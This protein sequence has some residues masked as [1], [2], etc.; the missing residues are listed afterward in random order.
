MARYE[1]FDQDTYK[2][3]KALRQDVKDVFNKGL[4]PGDDLM[5]QLYFLDPK[6]RDYVEKMTRAYTQVVTPDDFKQIASIMSGYLRQQ[7]PI[8]TEFTKYYGR[9]GEAYMK[10]AKPKAAAFDYNALMQ[11]AIRG[12]QNKGSRPSKTVPKWLLSILSIKDESIK[13]QL[14]RKIPG[15]VPGSTLSK[16]VEGVPV[17]TRRRTGTKIGGV[18]LFSEDIVKGIEVGIP[19]KL[20]KSWTNLPAVNF[21]RKVLEQNYTQVFEEKLSYKDKD[22]KWITNILQV[23]QKT[24]PTWWEQFRNKDGK[25]NDI[26][27]ASRARTAYGVSSNHSN[28]A[29]LVKRHHLWGL[30]NGIPTSTIHDAFM[31]NAQHM[32]ASRSGLRQIYAGAV[33]T[34]T[35]KWTLDEMLA[36]GFP[37]E[38][39]DQYLEEAEMLGI[40]PVA[41]K[42]IVGGKVLRAED[43]LKRS[44][45]LKPIKNDFKDNY[46]FYGI[47]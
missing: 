39:Y 33:D 47:G 38:L 5:E 46:S 35:L 16:I 8:L 9:L 40:I 10:N 7:V 43:I 21:D 1:S 23:P 41:G 20:D 36:R 15:Y 31:G 18:S 45:V 4:N 22:G 30:K 24:D 3:L 19:N 25:I 13:Q 11:T 42:S 32:I 27:D 14:L 6:S 37:K 28:D 26:A 34:Q 44:D 2:E 17:P 29:V 12:A